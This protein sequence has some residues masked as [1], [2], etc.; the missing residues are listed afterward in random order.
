MLAALVAVTLQTVVGWIVSTRLLLLARRT[1]ELPEALLGSSLLLSVSIGYPLRIAGPQLGSAALDWAGNACVSAGFA[2]FAL[3]VQRVF[4]AEAAWARGLAALLVASFAGQSLAAGGD[5]SLDAT[6]V[7][8]LLAIVTY[9]WGAL[10]AGARARRQGRQ[11][12]LGLGDRRVNVRLWL[13]TC[14]GLSVV[15][16]A[17]ANA[18]AIAAGLIALEEPLV[19]IVTTISGTCL[20]TTA[21]LA[22]APPR[23]FRARFALGA[24]A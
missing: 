9:A 14:H 17:L 2:L 19:L 24:A 13:F 18:A 1:R 7:Q 10:E 5:D 12:A 16:G 15:V 11:L 22:F 20:A 6:F 23:F 8:M 3:F 21:L 4:R